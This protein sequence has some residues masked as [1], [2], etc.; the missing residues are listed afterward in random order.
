MT[1]T[2]T[3]K[4]EVKTKIRAADKKRCPKS[5]N[6]GGLMADHRRMI[7]QKRRRPPRFHHQVRDRKRRLR[8]F[9]VGGSVPVRGQP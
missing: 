2:K 4:N 3:R 7:D 1:E 8:D 9:R 5:A 6:I